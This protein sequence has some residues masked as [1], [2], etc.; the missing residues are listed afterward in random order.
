MMRTI[1]TAILVGL[2]APATL[3]AQAADKP[4]DPEVR[5]ETVD[6]RV[7]TGRLV[8]LS[9]SEASLQTKTGLVK[10][11]LTDLSDMRFAAAGDPLTVPG[12]AVVVTA[13]GN[14]ITASGFTAAGGKV[15]FANESLGKVTLA[16]S[17]VTAFYL[18]SAGKT[19]AAVADKCAKLGIGSEQKDVV[20]V[21]QKSGKWLGVEGVLK[22][23]GA[24]TLTFSWKDTDR[25][26]NI[27]TVRAVF[28]AST[29]APKTEKFRGVLTLRDGSSV[30]FASLTYAKSQFGV[31]L[32]GPGAAEMKMPAD[33]IAAVKFVSDRVM[34]LGDLKPKSVK[35]HGLLDTT[36][37]WRTNRSVGG[38]PITLGGRKFSRGLGLHS[39]CEL[40][41][42]LDA[43][44]KA[45]I[46]VV[47]IDDLI[48]PG[49]DASL[50]FIGDGKEIIAPLRITGKGKPH[51]VRVPLAGVKIFIIRVDYGKDSLDVGDH[52]DLAG[53]RLI[54]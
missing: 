11:S 15:S 27:A 50:S 13:G 41:Y 19:A 45:L 52:V 51:S 39:F 24:K 21:A 47:G 53:A 33:K 10:I 29:G 17:R 14:K 12:R 23:I 32:A 1:I 5:T 46:A 7:S 26:I 9:G 37:K 3:F 40:T 22:S 44:Y 54:K 31:T 6:A 16:F 20:V 38:S 36:M 2:L 30:R 18:P 42:D 4:V 34:N 35:E 48:R 8:S 43:Q 49:G 25:E 28:L